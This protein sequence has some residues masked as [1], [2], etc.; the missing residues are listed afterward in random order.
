MRTAGMIN[1]H[2]AGVLVL[3]W[4]IMGGSSAMA[5]SK[6]LVVKAGDHDRAMVPMCVA[7]PSGIENPKMVDGDTGKAVACQVVDG[8][9]CWILEALPSGKTKTYTVSSDGGCAPVVKIAKTDHKYDVTVAG[10]AFTTFRLDPEE[11]RP[12]CYP[13]YGPKQVAMTRGFP[14]EEIEGEQRDH[15]H[16]RSFYVAHGEL[17]D[18]KYNFWHEPGKPGQPQKDQWDR[19]IV[20]EV[21]KAEGGPV[22]GTIDCL[23]DWTGRDGKKVVEEHRRLTFYAVDAPVR[24]IDMTVTFNAKYGKVHF[25]DTKEGGICSLR[26]A[27]EIRENGKCG[28]LLTTSEGLKTM[29]QGWG[30]KAKWVDYSRTKGQ[31]YGVAVF[32]TPGNLRYPTRW[33]IRD[34]GLFTANPFGSKCFDKKNTE[35]GDYNLEDGKQLVLKYRILLHEGDVDVAK[36]AARYEDYVDPPKAEWK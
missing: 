13:L 30:K 35:P 19:Q 14:M 18:K 17:Q 32:D 28:G 7:A 24:I 15:H 11:I 9:L 1:R 16:H 31:Q 27:K 20:R 8:K 36:I 25:G 6:Q 10:K 34:Y 21:V 12:Y 4:G 5:Q 33:H 26:V 22:L 23:I 2:V 3:A 29:R